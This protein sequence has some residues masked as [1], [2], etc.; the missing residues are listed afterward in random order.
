M[1]VH[2][3]TR[4]QLVSR[5]M[6][7]RSHTCART[8]NPN[9]IF[10]SEHGNTIQISLLECGIRSPIPHHN[11]NHNYII[12]IIHLH[13]NFMDIL[14]IYLTTNVINIAKLIYVQYHNEARTWI[15]HTI[16]K[17]QPSPTSKQAWNPKKHDS[18]LLGFFYLFFV[19]KKSQ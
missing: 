16:M 12:N 8:W 10:M 6:E 19:Y 5:N 4:S 1:L 7:I 14:F 18:S 15:H 17:S 11:H 3:W 9:P 13:Y 2:R